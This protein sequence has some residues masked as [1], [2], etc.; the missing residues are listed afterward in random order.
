MS[1]PKPWERR[2]DE[3]AKNFHAFRAYRDQPA[4]HRSIANVPAIIKKIPK[5]C[6]ILEK[7]SQK[8]DWVARA[9][10]WDDHLDSIK[11][12]S[13]EDEVAEM[14][15]RHIQIAMLMQQKGVKL[16]KKL[17]DAEYTSPSNV[18]TMLKSA[19]EIERSARGAA[20]DDGELSNNIPDWIQDW[21]KPKEN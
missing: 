2:D 13:V 3:T 9:K 11:V 7:W 16:L 5:Y 14:N 20:S 10:A 19:I 8:F 18:A 15:K 21:V 17:D 4:S 6:H 1:D 12:K